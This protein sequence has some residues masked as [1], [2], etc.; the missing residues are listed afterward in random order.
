M[1][2]AAERGE[3]L[4]S[5]IVGA[6]HLRVIALAPLRDARPARLRVAAHAKALRR[7]RSVRASLA[8]GGRCARQGLSR[9]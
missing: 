6:R 3:A 2:A 5:F 9:D 1:V 7:Q 8:P 4:L